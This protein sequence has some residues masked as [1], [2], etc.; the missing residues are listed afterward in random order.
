MSAWM[1]FKD[2]L[3]FPLQMGAILP[4][5]RFLARAMVD[6]G[7][8][9]PWALWREQ[10][11]RFVLDLLLPHLAPGARLVTFHYLHSR[12]FGRVSAMRGALRER[13]HHVSDSRTVWANFPP[14]YVHIAE[15]PRLDHVSGAHETRRPPNGP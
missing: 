2:A 11:Q 6:H 14:A 3:R 10:R 13:F 7:S 12:M 8:G 1:F 15:G 4:S 9:L 5:S